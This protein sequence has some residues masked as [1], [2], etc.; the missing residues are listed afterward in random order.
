[1]GLDEEVEEEEEEE[2]VEGSELRFKLLP[3]MAEEDDWF[4]QCSLLLM[5]LGEEE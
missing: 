2:V 3:F 5:L 1:M 4:K